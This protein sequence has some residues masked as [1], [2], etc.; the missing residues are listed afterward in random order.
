MLVV[1]MQIRGRQFILAALGGF[2]CRGVVP[3]DWWDYDV[4]LA[5]HESLPLQGVSEIRTLAG[6]LWRARDDSGI[7][8]FM[9]LISIKD[10][11]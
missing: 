7:I 8:G 1:A 2:A 4:Q 5:V 6:F 3:S 10:Y 9:L 11:P